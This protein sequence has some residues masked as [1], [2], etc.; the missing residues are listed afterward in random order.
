MQPVSKNKR[1]T[2]FIIDNIIIVSSLSVTSFLFSEK[3]QAI[4]SPIAFLL[5]YLLLEYYNNGQTVGKKFSKTKVVNLKGEKPSFKAIFIRSLL[6]FNPVY[7]FSFLFGNE[8]GTHDM[9][10]KTRVIDA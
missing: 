9:L 6:R 5:Y 2:N 1:L 10:S 3:T 4:Q 7:I 8:I